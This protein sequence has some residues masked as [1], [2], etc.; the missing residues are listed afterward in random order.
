MLSVLV[1]ALLLLE[2]QQP[3][4]ATGRL[5]VFLDCTDCFAD[6]VRRPISSIS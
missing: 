6:C 1:F 5:Q 2:Q 3:P 4:T